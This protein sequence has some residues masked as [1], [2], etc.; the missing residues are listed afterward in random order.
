MMIKLR[1]INGG[2]LETQLDYESLS[3]IWNLENTPSDTIELL[4]DK[5]RDQIN[6]LTTKLD[7]QVFQPFYEG[8]IYLKNRVDYF[9]KASLEKS[10]HYPETALLFSFLNL[11]GHLQQKLNSLSQKYLD[12]YYNDILKQH[13]EEPIPDQVYLTYQALSDWPFA[14]IKKGERFQA[15]EYPNGENIIYESDYELEVNQATVK[16]V[17]YH[18]YGRR[19]VLDGTEKKA[20]S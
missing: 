8:L 18:L 19:F 6:D 4:G 2:D 15:G 3:S 9:F 11:F 14:I 16:Q 1:E 12:F 17:K 20:C 13:I 10:T 5:P 7:L